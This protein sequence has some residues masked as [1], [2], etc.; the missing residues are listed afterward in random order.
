[1]GGQKDTQRMNLQQMEEE[2]VSC[3]M[4]GLLASS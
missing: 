3:K 4:E 1:M 2:A